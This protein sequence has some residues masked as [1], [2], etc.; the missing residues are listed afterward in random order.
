MSHY[1]RF[2]QEIILSA[3]IQPYHFQEEKI[4]H[5]KSTNKNLFFLYVMY[6]LNFNSILHTSRR[7]ESYSKKLL[8]IV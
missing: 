5:T 7:C 4:F 3:V 8:P 2:K 1:Y 6:C